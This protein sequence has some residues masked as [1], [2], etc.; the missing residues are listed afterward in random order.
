MEKDKYLPLTFATSE[1]KPG[2][3]SGVG[4]RRRALL[5][6]FVFQKQGFGVCVGE[7]VGF[8]AD[9]Q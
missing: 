1:G 9:L 4:G 7:K 3:G 8:K 2:V 6:L 5:E